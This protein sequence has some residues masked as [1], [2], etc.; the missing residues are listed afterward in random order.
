[1]KEP[2]ANVSSQTKDFEP[3]N[4]QKQNNAELCEFKGCG[5]FGV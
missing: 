5:T 2:V 1:M 4:I 3:Q